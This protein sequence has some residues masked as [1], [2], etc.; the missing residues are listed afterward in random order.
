MPG[1]PRRC[2]VTVEH[3]IELLHASSWPQQVSMRS[4]Y[5]RKNIVPWL[6]RKG[7]RL[8]VAE[9]RVTMRGLF[10]RQKGERM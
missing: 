4:P 10:G 1:R 7:S 8:F 2:K 3:V 6:H 9:P 5:A